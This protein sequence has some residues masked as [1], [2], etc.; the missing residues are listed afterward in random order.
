MRKILLGTVV[1]VFTLVAA[2]A[3]VLW[4][5]PAPPDRKPALAESP[6]L[7]PATRTSV[8]RRAGRDRAQRRSAMRSTHRRRAI[9]PASAKI[10]SGNCCRMPSSAG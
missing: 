8:D 9:S 4:L 5:A 6:P 7:K 10:R 1:L 2:L 3:A